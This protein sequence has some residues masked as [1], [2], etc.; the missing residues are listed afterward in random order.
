MSIKIKISL[1]LVVAFLISAGLYGYLT[2][3]L[4]GESHDQTSLVVGVDSYR[5]PFV[6]RD[7]NGN[8]IGF[9]IDLSQE[10]CKIL[11]RKCQFKTY[12]INTLADSIR[13]REIDIALS[14]IPYT[15]KLMKDLSFSIVYYRSRS[16]FI[17]AESHENDLTFANAKNLKIGVRD[18]T[19][20]FCFLKETYAVKGSEIRSYPTYKDM[21]AALNAGEVGVI[22]VGGIPGYK[23][24]T[25]PMGRMLFA[26]GFSE[27]ATQA[28]D[29]FR[30]VAHKDDHELIEQINQALFEL[31]SNGKFHTLTSR[32]LPDNHFSQMTYSWNPTKE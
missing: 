9:S 21:I 13:S 17:S 1:V 29:E 32:Y 23:I 27:I 10:I 20:Q 15:P 2:S 4:E 14:E 8:L 5:P 11:N 26:V 31:Y 3:L 6:Y 16:F 30:I 22:F 7:D 19:P 18:N 24:L 25:S 28:L 12:A